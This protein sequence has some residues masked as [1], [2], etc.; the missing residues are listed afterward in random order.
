MYH[1]EKPTF[2]CTKR[3]FQGCSLHRLVNVMDITI[4]QVYSSLGQEREGRERDFMMCRAIQKCA[5]HIS[6]M[7]SHNCKL[8]RFSICMRYKGT[9]MVY[10]HHSGHMMSIHCRFNVDT[11]PWGCSDIDT[12]SWTLWDMYSVCWHCVMLCFTAQSSYCGHVDTV[13]WPTYILAIS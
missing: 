10:K 1:L 11:T 5:F 4:R 6:V 8:S 2:P 12:T 13:S 7:M 9:I 3:G